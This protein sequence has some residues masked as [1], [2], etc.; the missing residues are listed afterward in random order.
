MD[1]KPGQLVIVTET[2]GVECEKTSGYGRVWT[3]NNWP[4]SHP[5]DLQIP[6]GQVCLVLGEPLHWDFLGDVWSLPVLIE[7]NELGF[8]HL[9]VG[10][11]VKRARRILSSGSFA[12]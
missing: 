2:H 1:Y 9:K 10:I 6:K 8:V 7:N 12:I 3:K 4:Y 11:D 5:D